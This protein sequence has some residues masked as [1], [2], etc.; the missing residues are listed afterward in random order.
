MGFS[1]F[2]AQDRPQKKRRYNPN[3]DAAVHA[4]STA[5]SSSS[6]QGRG[7]QTT[8]SNSTPLGARPAAPQSAANAHEIDLDGE[9]DGDG[10]PGAGGVDLG[11]AAVSAQGGDAA[12]QFAAGSDLTADAAHLH[13]L[14]QRPAQFAADQA[15][16]PPNSHGYPHG[17]GQHHSAGNGAPWYEGY[18]DT[19]SNRNPWEKLEKAMGLS[20]KGTW[21]SHEE[22][23]AGAA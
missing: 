8:G 5:S 3:A 12:Q 18:Y 7:K 6:R 2:G 14:P 4:A 9:E 13:G 22:H 20:A 16:G 11:G 19:L 10:A 1:S 15:R 23:A 21:V 17:R